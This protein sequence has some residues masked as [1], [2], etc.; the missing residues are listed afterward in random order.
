VNSKF[1]SK[2]LPKCLCNQL[3]YWILTTQLYSLKLLVL[4]LR[5]AS[6][7]PYQISSHSHLHRLPVNICCTF[8]VLLMS[9]PFIYALQLVL[10]TV[11]G[12]RRI[13]EPALSLK[14]CKAWIQPWYCYC[15]SHHQS[16]AKTKLF[17]NKYQK[18]P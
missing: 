18:E 9:N 6:C 3:P 4:F 16:P 1:F 12:I 2:Q 15:V 7:P 10:R 13:L 14:C 8:S 11:S 5:A 17:S